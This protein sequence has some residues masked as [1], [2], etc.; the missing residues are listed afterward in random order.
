LLSSLVNKSLVMAETQ[1]RD[2]AHY[3]LL[4]TIRQY[5][6]EKLIAAGER[7]LLRDRHL[8]CYLKLAA[9]T[10]PKLRGVYQQLWLNWLEAEY[11][12]IRV[13]L[14][15]S[16]ESGQVEAGLRLAIALGEYDAARRMLDEGLPLLRELGD[17]YRI[18]MALNYVGDLARC[19]GDYTQAQGAYEESLSL[20]QEI[21]AVRDRAS[22]LH[23]LGHTCLH[24]GDIERAQTLF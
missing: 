10:E 18:A 4:E 22:V 9:E 17:P 24:L 23:N 6:Q 15:W 20:L 16:L 12:N 8:Q 5:A 11:D 3:T 2:E 21:D 14:A 13:A 7:P 19:E 1:R